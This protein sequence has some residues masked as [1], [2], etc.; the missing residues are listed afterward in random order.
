[1]RL[2]RAFHLVQISDTHLGRDR[3]WFLPNFRAMARIISAL[4]PDLVV[5][6]GD[7]SFDGADRDDDLAFARS[8]HADLD[9]PLLA[10]PGNHDVG[11][12]PWQRDIPKESLNKSSVVASAVL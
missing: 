3:S 7:I 12:N 2:M 8:C 6:T 10:I 1:M 11:D 9:V 5:N 4:R